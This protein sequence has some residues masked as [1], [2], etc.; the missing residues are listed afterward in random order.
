MTQ[1]ALSERL[2]RAGC[3]HGANVYDAFNGFS[4]HLHSE[5]DERFEGTFSIA[6]SQ[7]IKDQHK[8]HM[9]LVTCLVGWLLLQPTK[10]TTKGCM[11]LFRADNLSIQNCA[12]STA[13]GWTWAFHKIRP[14]S[15]VRSQ[16]SYTRCDKVVLA[17]MCSF[18]M[19][20]NRFGC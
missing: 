3:S 14:S 1:E 11:T 2:R 9:S 20:H 7:R 15:I 8:F 5:I 17:Y 16:V 10:C 19:W 4:S 12:V 13:P 18:Q 6:D